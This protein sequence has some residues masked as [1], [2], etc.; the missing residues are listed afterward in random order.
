MLL[1]QRFDR[2]SGRGS[3][4]VSKRL[5]MRQT[6]FHGRQVDGGNR[7]HRQSHHFTLQ[8]DFQNLIHGLHEIDLH[9][10]LD[11]VRNVREILLVLPRDDCLQYAVPVRRHQL[12]LQSADGQH[13]ATEGDFTGHGHVA[14]HRNACQGAANGGGQ[15]DAGRRTV[16]GDG[17]LGNVDMH[18]EVAVKIARQTERGGT[19]ADVAHGGLRGFLH[20]LAQFAG[21]GEFAFAFHQR[22]FG[23]EELAASITVEAAQGTS[24]Y[25]MVKYQELVSSIIVQDPDVETFYSM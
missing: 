6:L 8:R 18:V 19:R 24:Y 9:G 11:G 12:L 14:A 3:G 10:F 13:L 20:Y 23:G 7:R 5:L 15:S 4:E 2:L 22:A 25:Q 16:L 1:R 21:D 17:A